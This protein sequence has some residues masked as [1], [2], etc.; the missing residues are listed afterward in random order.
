MGYDGNTLAETRLQ[1]TVYE[2]AWALNGYRVW[3]RGHYTNFNN[4]VETTNWFGRII[5]A[6]F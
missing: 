6:N 2:K 3:I 1:F 4:Q 5:N